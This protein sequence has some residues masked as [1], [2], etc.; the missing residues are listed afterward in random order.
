MMIYLCAKYTAF[1]CVQS[2]P[3]SF[4]CVCVTMMIVKQCM[5]SQQKHSTDC[6]AAVF[7]S[8][9]DRYAPVSYMI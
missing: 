2:T 5:V 4:V 1:I 8:I 6:E 3:H 7:D 9:P